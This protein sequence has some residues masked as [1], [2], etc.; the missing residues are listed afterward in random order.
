MS[1]LEI[2]DTYINVYK[3][4]EKIYSF[5]WTRL[6][7]YW[8]YA[9]EDDV[10]GIRADYDNYVLILILT[11]ASG[12]GGIVAVIDIKSDSIV[13]VHDGAFA[14]KSLIACENIITLSHVM[15]YGVKPSYYIDCIQK[16]NLEMIESPKYMQI[17]CDINFDDDNIFLSLQNNMLKISD[18]VNE[19]EVDISKL[20]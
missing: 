14:V 5:D 19:T 12:Q 1:R 10:E 7:S 3:E 2:Q 11:T 8:S 13:H 16:D 18:G 20:L 9:N 6:K 17:K 4:N 15:Y